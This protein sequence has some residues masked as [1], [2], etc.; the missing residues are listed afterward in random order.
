MLFLLN[1]W[2]LRALHLPLQWFSILHAGGA[3]QNI[4]ND[5][6]VDEENYIKYFMETQNKRVELAGELFPNHYDFLNGWYNT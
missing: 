3:Y 1:L 4:V 6:T 5:L 2:R